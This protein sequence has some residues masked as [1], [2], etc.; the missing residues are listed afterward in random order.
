[1]VTVVGDV[2]GGRTLTRDQL[3]TR[4]V[5][6]DL[7]PRGAVVAIH[8]A[9]GRTPAGPLSAGT[10]LTEAALVGPGLTGLAAGHVAVPARLADAGIVQVLRVGDAIDVMATDTGT[11][12]VRRV[13]TRA[14]V[15]TIPAQ[16]D[17]GPLSSGTAQDV[18]V[19]LDV[20]AVEAAEVTRAAATSRLSVVLP[21]GSG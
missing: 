20:T 8:L 12:E 9:E 13:A 21:G 19:L 17:G 14:R 4:S 18:L 11:G 16:A 5:P 6:T 3:T 10:I 1:M 2:T 15:A 7:V